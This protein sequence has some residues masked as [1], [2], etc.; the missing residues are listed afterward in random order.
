MQLNFN[1][2]RLRERLAALSISHQIAF[3]ASC[4]ERAAPTYIEFSE[5]EHLP[6]GALVEEVQR[7]TWLACLDRKAGVTER[8]LAKQLSRA[9]MQMKDWYPSELHTFAS[10]CLVVVYYAAD[11]QL[12][13]SVKSASECGRFFVRG[14]RRRCHQP[15]RVY[16]RHS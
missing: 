4:C 9:G 6:T 1:E 5:L 3:V 14:P 12:T 7:R 15:K 16:K 8:G 2:T 13:G 10:P 11:F